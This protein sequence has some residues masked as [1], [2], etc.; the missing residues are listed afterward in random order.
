MLVE[1]NPVRVWSI[2]K[3]GLRR[4]GVSQEA[5]KCLKEAH[6]LLFRSRLPRHE[7]LDRLFKEHSTVPEVMALA[8]FAIN[9]EKGNQGRARQ[10][11]IR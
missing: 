9:T 6:K 4:N 3:V 1:G 2:N 11:R 10:P 5:M 7:V 8:Q